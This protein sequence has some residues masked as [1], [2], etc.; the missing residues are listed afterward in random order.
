MHQLWQHKNGYWYVLHGPRLR[1]QISTQTKDRGEAEKFL[2][3]FIAIEGEP[4]GIPTVGEL[5]NN[6]K[7]HKTGS[8]RAPNSLHYSVQGLQPLKDLYP[9]QLTPRVMDKWARERGASAGT[10]LRDVGVLRAALTHGVQD[11]WLTRDQLPIISNPVPTPQ[12]RKRWLDKD[13]GRRLIAGC[14]TPHM[15]LFVVMGLMTLAR[16]SAILEAKW[17]QVNWDRRFIDYGAGHGNK[18]RAIPPLNDEVFPMLQAAHQ[19]ACSDF[20]IEYRGDRVHTVKTGFAAAVERAGLSDDVT[21]HVLRHSGA[22]WLVEAGISDDDVARMM[23]DTPEMV[24]TTYGHFRPEYLAR[25]T[26]A[27][28]L[29]I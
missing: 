19:L 1:R 18:R 25:T 16:T 2:A 29:G 15:R 24:R 28:K 21:P 6:Y 26:A 12:G 5:L 14:Q 22:S 20:I 4:E 7:T 13:E 17:P 9:T 23:G 8:V 11:Q 10:I 27:L 3:R